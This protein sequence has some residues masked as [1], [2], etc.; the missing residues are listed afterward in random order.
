MA[1]EP[2]A[3]TLETRE[4][5]DDSTT[6]SSESNDTNSQPDISGTG[7]ADPSATDPAATSSTDETPWITD[8]QLAQLG[9]PNIDALKQSGFYRGIQK[10][11]T[12]RFQEL[13]SHKGLIE[14]FQ[15][16]PRGTLAYLAEQMGGRL[17]W[18]DE[19]PATQAQPRQAPQD[20]TEAALEAARAQLNEQFGP[21]GAEAILRVAK[22]L[23]EAQVTPIK[24]Q[25]TAEQHAKESAAVTDT[26]ARFDENFPGW[27][28]Y[29]SKM[30][31]LGQQMPLAPG[32]DRYAYM[33]R[34]YKLVNFDGAVAA[35]IA[36]QK[37][38]VD[39][40]VRNSTTDTP[41][42][43]SDRGVTVSAPQAK[44]LNTAVRLAFEAAKRGEKFARR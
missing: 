28:Q 37:G 41:A 26:V 30:V 35:H 43:P 1:T 20:P 23:T 34:L 39:S 4:P 11:M 44:N 19:T 18:G 36:K 16:N 13:A 40:A 42:A 15:V 31:Q 9:V 17:S 21:S 10:A 6:P 33:E 24:K 27:R 5:V 25:L 3:P 14:T 32:G 38:K 7:P 8:E 22:S 12:Q 2:V 29:E